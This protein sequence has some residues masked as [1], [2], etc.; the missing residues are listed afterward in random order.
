MYSRVLKSASLIAVL[1]FV[2]LVPAALVAQDSAK[3]AAKSAPYTGDSPSRWDI[4]LG[5]SYMA[6]VGT[7]NTYQGDCPVV[8]TPPYSGITIGKGV[9][10]NYSSNTCG[11]T[12]PFS[13]Q[14]IDYGAIGSAARFF[15]KYTGLEFDAGYH[16]NRD[17]RNTGVYNYGVGPVFRLPTDSIIPFAHIL[18]GAD[19]IGGPDTQPFT[20]GP[21]VGIGGGI[22]YPTHFFDKH[23]SI[24]IFQYDY[25]YAHVNYGGSAIPYAGRANV[26]L[27][28]L[29]TGVVI[30]VG[31]LA[32]PP[33]VTLS[34]KASPESVF[35]GEDVTVAGTAGALNPKLST[36]Y[37]WTGS[38]VTGDGANA[39][40]DTATLAPGSYTVKGHVTQG[41]KPW[42][43]ADCSTQFTVKEFEP[44]TITCKADPATIKPGESSTV[45]SEASSPQ[46]RP[47]KITYSA[48]AGQ[49]NGSG[50]TA[51]FT[52]VEGTPIDTINITCSVSDDKGH[53]ASA[54]T[55][56]TVVKPYV[57][58]APKAS[59]L[60]S[61]TFG[62][63][64]QPIARVDNEAKGCLDDVALNLQKQP[65]AKLVVIGEETTKELGPLGK[66][67]HAKA[68][69]YTVAA[70]R[71]VNTKAYLVEDKQID[72]SRISVATDTGDAQ[73]AKNIL[74]PAGAP[75]DASGTT[76]VDETKVKPQSRTRAQA[77]A[78][79]LAAAKNKKAAA[80]TKKA[81]T[82]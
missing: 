81:A 41:V 13:Y 31:S 22:D 1:A 21:S 20:W 3:P 47:L 67:K 39:K 50:N 6:P 24:R 76:P 26:K 53:T 75:Y 43:S 77:H 14:S 79:A 45:T 15:N 2:A 7:V 63:K 78:A 66:G 35:P 82:K 40:V 44:P 34:C 60:C 32:P 62:K 64:T 42:M 10:A 74:V 49:I 16:P 80:K 51:T 58:P 17:Y 55:S 12:E 71:A 61:I 29:S 46:N 56:V 68:P 52:A 30:H 28:Q 65:D 25:S 57:P 72:P 8:V 4:F 27:N 38:N 54:N 18:I 73:Q 37:S 36:T 69:K 33:Q 11:T 59:D 19:R 48:A 70:Q 9:Q 23:L 5:Y